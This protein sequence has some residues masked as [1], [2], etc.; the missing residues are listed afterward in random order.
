M[1]GSHVSTGHVPCL[2]QA[3][4]CDDAHRVRQRACRQVEER[5]E[6]P[7]K[8]RARELAEAK[9]PVSAVSAQLRPCVSHMPCSPAVLGAHPPLY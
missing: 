1:T 9:D 3:D 2:L 4:V 7:E 8:R 5:L 6:D